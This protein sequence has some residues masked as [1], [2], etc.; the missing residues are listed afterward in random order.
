MGDA[1]LL[2]AA[3]RD[4]LPDRIAVLA[5]IHGNSAALRA[6]L[7]DLDAVEPQALLVLGD[8]FSGPL[9]AGGT[10]GLLLARP[11]HALRGNHD[12][13]L[14]DLP[15]EEMGPSD[16]V[17]HDA[18]PDAARDWLRHLPPALDFGDVWACHATP[19]DDAT[20]WTHVATAEGQVAPR[21]RSDIAA[22]AQGL[23]AALLLCAHTHLPGIWRLPTG[24]LLLN[25]GSVGCP[26]YDDDQPIPHVV[27]AGHPQASYALVSRQGVGWQVS[28]RH[29]PYDA[30]AMAA[31]ARAH[32]RESWA[33]AVTLGHL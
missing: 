11:C 17:A 32:G 26:A 22:R 12:R 13:H 25:P 3:R 28:L 7:R 14:L 27:E 2:P 18:L 31:R 33:R 29:I 4:P 10:A 21:S 19:Q 30:T 16:R 9:D 20:Y 15:P 5:D 1:P 24:Q 23:S 6:V 8:H